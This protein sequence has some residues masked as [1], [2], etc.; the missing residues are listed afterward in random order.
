MVIRNKEGKEG[1]YIFKNP[2]T[3]LP[4]TGGSDFTTVCL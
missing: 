4:L 1:E 2:I 3:N